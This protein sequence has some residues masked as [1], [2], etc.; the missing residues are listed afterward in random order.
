M[1]DPI[2]FIPGLLCTE[3]LFAPQISAFADR[4]IMVA[5]HRDH[6]SIEAI[7]GHILDTAPERFS[8]IGLSMGGYIAMEVLRKAPHRVGKLA[9]LDTNARAD[10]SDKT[11]SRELLIKIT[12]N[13]GFG[14]VPHLL[15][16]GLVHE[17]RENDE[18][19]KAIIIDMAQDTGPDAFVRQQTALINRPD[20]RP[21][22][23]EITCP[24]LVLVGDGDRL[25]PPDISREIHALIPGSELALVKDCGHLSTLENPLEVTQLLRE[26]LNTA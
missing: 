17:S 12:R 11:E 10:T 22:L 15:Y 21:Q 2:V 23:S 4:P 24:T 3:A 19:L 8:L 9:L 25:T 5:N 14:K 26:F 18:D 7:A 6:D 20:A 1:G 16:P 13:R